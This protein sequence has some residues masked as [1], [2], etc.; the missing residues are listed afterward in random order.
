M[1]WQLNRSGA[2][3]VH[4]FYT[5]LLAAPLVSFPWKSIWYVKVP[6][7]MAFFLWTDARG[8]LLTI[9]NHVNKKL[10]LVNWCCLCRCEEETVDHLLIHCKYAYTLWSEVLRF[11]GVQWVMQKNEGL[12]MRD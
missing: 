4:S 11:F 3:N 1:I 7:R 5:S 6:K 8:G 12:K 2:F 9:D 10:P